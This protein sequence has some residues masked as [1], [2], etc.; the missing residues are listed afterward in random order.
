MRIWL[1]SLLIGANVLQAQ[2]GDLRGIWKAEGAAHLNLETA[3]V[4]VDPPSGK[5]PYRAEARAKASENFVRRATA[6]PDARCFQPGVPRAAILP[7][8]FQS[9]DLARSQAAAFIPDSVPGRKTTQ[10]GPILRHGRFQGPLGRHDL[11]RRCCKL[12]R[13]NVAGC[14]RASSQRG[15]ARGGAIYTHESRD[16]RLRGYH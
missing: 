7:Y 15:P 16:N 5:I 1:L 11:N 4:I 3:G 13:S 12:Q 9:T 10:R 14:R 6:D 8:P 2:K